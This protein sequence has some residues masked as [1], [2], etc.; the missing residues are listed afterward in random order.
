MLCPS[1][2]PFFILSSSL[3]IEHRC[4]HKCAT[5]AQLSKL[6]QIQ[7]S[8]SFIVKT[9]IHTYHTAILPLKSCDKSHRTTSWDQVYSCFL[10]CVM[11]LM[12]IQIRRSLG[13]LV[14]PWVANQYD[15]RVKQ[16]IEVL[17]GVSA[18]ELSVLLYIT[19][20]SLVHQDGLEWNPSFGPWM[21]SLYRANLHLFNIS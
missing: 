4:L 21:P 19:I 11:W 13:N 6:I 8:I 10:L 17:S 7:F 16:L 5:L 3:S 20:N 1:S 14:P 12:K 18:H 15:L 2:R 9:A